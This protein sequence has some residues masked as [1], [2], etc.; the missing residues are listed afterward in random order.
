[1][2]FILYV[3]II[4]NTSISVHTERFVTLSQCEKAKAQIDYMVRVG[5]Y[6]GAPIRGSIVACQSEGV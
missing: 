6:N 5:Q 1:M 3:L 4:G 2:G